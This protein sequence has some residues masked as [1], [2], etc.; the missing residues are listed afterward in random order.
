MTASWAKSAFS[1]DFQNDSKKFKGEQ[2]TQL[3]KL[4]PGFLMIFDPQL[5]HFISLCHQP[6]PAT[7]TPSREDCH[8]Q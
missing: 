3:G 2:K 6:E 8:C 1:D 7:C 4:I 5:S